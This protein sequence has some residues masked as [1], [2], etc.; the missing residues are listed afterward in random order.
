[1]RFLRPSLCLTI[2]DH[3]RNSDKIK[4][5]Q[6]SWLDHLVRMDR[7]HLPKLAFRHPGMT[8][9]WKI[10]ENIESSRMAWASQ[11]QVLQPNT[12]LS[13]WRRRKHKTWPTQASMMDGLTTIFVSWQILCNEKCC[14]GIGTVMMQNSLVWPKIWYFWWMCCCEHSTILK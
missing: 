9:C 6:I 11:K 5:Y 12:C 8:G 1:M 2:L 7:S 4:L 3:Q 10:Q 13:L 14:V